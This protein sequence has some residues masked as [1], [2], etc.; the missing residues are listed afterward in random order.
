VRTDLVDDR[1]LDV[2]L[3]GFAERDLDR[4]LEKAPRGVKLAAAPATY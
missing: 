4:I 3:A 2:A 1:G